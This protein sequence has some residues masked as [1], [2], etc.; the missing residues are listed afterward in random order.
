[1]PAGGYEDYAKFMLALPG[2]ARQIA[3]RTGMDESGVRRLAR[4]FWALGLAHPGGRKPAKAH[5]PVEAI[6]RIGEGPKA[7]GLRVATPMRPLSQHIAWKYLWRALEDGGT[8]QELREVTGLGNV[9]IR[10]A[11]LALP[12]YVCEYEVD[13]LGRPVAVWKLGKKPDAPRP[14]PPTEGEKWRAYQKRKAWRVL[15]QQGVAT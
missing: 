11:L 5:Q 10:R 6:W 14:A 7:D 12:V 13:A 4:S 2:T 8:K 9:T 1:M 15:A 3:K